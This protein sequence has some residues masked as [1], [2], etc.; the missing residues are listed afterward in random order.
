MLGDI[1]DLQFEFDLKNTQKSFMSKNDV[2]IL[3][4][5]GTVRYGNGYFDFNTDRKEKS[6]DSGIT[7]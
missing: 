7:R 2:K 6:E 1:Q 4:Q 3:A 5:S